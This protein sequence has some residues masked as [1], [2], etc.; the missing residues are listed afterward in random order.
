MPG[1]SGRSLARLSNKQT[2]SAASFVQVLRIFPRNRVPCT[3]AF[4]LGLTPRHLVRRS[5]GTLP[6]R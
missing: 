4:Y 6:A 3:P 5:L 2:D 1:E